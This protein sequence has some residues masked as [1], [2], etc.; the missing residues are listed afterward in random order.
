MYRTWSFQLA[1]YWILSGPAVP[2]EASARAT[3]PPMASERRRRFIRPPGVRVDGA[4]VN[5]AA[6]ATVPGRRRFRPGG[7]YWPRLATWRRV[8][9]R[10][11]EAIARAESIS[12]WLAP[13]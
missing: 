2:G 5:T 9:A 12:S 1:G 8:S 6:L 3:T 11:S 7:G 10:A 13:R 4:A